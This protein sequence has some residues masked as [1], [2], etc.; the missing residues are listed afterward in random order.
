[1]HKFSPPQAV[2]VSFPAGTGGPLTRAGK[3][4]MP[5]DFD[6]SVR[7]NKFKQIIYVSIYT[8]NLTNDRY[9]CRE[10]ET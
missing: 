5:F 3:W 10:R 8:Y 6:R 1:M 7:V 9:T 4:S 2:R